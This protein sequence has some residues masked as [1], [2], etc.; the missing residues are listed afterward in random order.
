[1]GCGRHSWSAQSCVWLIFVWT[2]ASPCLSASASIFP[3]TADVCAPTSCGDDCSERLV[4]IGF[5][6]CIYSYAFY[7][8]MSFLGEDE[9]DFLREKV[10]L[11][12]LFVLFLI[13]HTMWTA[14]FFLSFDYYENAKEGNCPGG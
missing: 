8:L 7:A 12:G 6:I 3:F 2:V 5:G 4:G 10:V 1:M 11:T 9:A 14:G 13:A